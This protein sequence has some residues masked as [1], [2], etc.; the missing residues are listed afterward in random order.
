MP[1]KATYPEGKVRELQCRLWTCA[2]RSKTR[3]FHA[4]YDRICR[5][6]VL[7]E[8]WKRVKANRGAAGVDEETL[9]EIEASGVEQFL[10]NIQETLRAGKYRPQPVRRRV[11]ELTDIRR[12]RARDLRQLIASL[13]PL[14]RGWGNY[15]RSGNADREFNRIDS[16]VYE[17]LR[18]WHWRG[19]GQRARHFGADWPSARYH[20]LGLYRLRGTVCYPVHATPVR[21]S[22]SRVRESR[23]HGL[24]GGAGTVAA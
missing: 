9:A 22:L 14:L 21:S 2:K 12:S 13:N 6:D 18:R 19:G 8:A 20:R 4:L 17:R 24:K 1:V 16:Y 10:R 5:S 23:T 11:H 7:Q 15:F 3:R